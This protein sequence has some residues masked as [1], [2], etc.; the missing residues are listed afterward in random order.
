M[1]ENTGFGNIGILESFCKTIVPVLW[2]KKAGIKA[3]KRRENNVIP[4]NE[5]KKLLKL[6][7]ARLR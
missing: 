4:L 6:N 7:N 3:F 2:L 5:N 1:I